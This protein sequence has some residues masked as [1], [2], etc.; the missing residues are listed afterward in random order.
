MTI[1]VNHCTHFWK[2]VISLKLYQLTKIRTIG[3]S[4]ITL[5]SSNIVLAT[6]TELVLAAWKSLIIVTICFTKFTKI[7]IVKIK[8]IFHRR[9]NF[10]IKVNSEEQWFCRYLHRHHELPHEIIDNIFVNLCLENEEMHSVIA[11]VCKKWSR[12]IN[13]EFVEK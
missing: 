12:H 2:A 10:T 4:F 13:K 7:L 6:D 11:L 5:V 1:L 8:S 3:F 9:P